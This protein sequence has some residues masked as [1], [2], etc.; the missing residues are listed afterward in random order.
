MT[1]AI[2]AEARRSKYNN[3][4]TEVDGITFSSKKE[5]RRYGELKLLAKAG[6]I[7]DLQTQPRFPLDVNGQP[8]C[9]YVGDFAYRT[10]GN[11]A[12]TVEDVKSP[13]TRKNPVYRLKIK[14]LK[15]VRGIEVVEI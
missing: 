13:I 14:L 1:R 10:A 6:E 5:A 3:K 15:A 4:P 11:A 7:F 9:A 12:L 8:V 2:L